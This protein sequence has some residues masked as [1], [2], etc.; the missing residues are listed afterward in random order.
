MTSEG[1]R[2]PRQEYKH[3]WYLANKDKARA[4]QERNREARRE[5]HRK[6]YRDNRDKV[7]EANLRRKHGIR[8]EDLVQMY[9]A[10]GGRCYL[11]GDLLPADRRQWA[12]DHD[13][14]CDEKRSCRYCRRGLACH[15]CNF[16]IGHAL[17]NPERLR[18]IAASL[19]VAIADVTRRLAD[20]AI[21]GELFEPGETDKVS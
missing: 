9:E 3:N 18:R 4:S 19:E 21:Q 7:L 11:C 17:D 10:Q 13:H 2:S 1:N 16:L 6:R 8:P 14:R 12:I 5:H 20:K 15:P